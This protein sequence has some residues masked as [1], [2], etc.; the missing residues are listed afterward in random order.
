L[1]ELLFYS[2]AKLAAKSF[3]PIL[4]PRY[5]IIKLTLCDPTKK[6]RERHQSLPNLESSLVLIVFQSHDIIRISLMSFYPMVDLVCLSISR[7]WLIAIFNDAFLQTIQQF[8]A[9]RQR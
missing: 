9:F 2:D 1:F 7:R 6:R 5:C 8:Q 3:T 4:I